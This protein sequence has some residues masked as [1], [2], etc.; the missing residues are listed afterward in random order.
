M[1]GNVG[2][3]LMDFSSSLMFGLPNKRL[4]KDIFDFL[5]TD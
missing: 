5:S 3:F 1:V 4:S 2:H